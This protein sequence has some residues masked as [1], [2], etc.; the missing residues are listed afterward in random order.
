MALVILATLVLPGTSEAGTPG[1]VSRVY[2]NQRGDTMPYQ[3]FVPANYDATRAYPLV[4]WL[5]GGGG[6]G[7]DNQKQMTD[8]N[9]VGATIWTSPRNQARYPAFVLAPQC[10]DGEMWTTIRPTVEP[11]ARLED[12][13]ALVKQLQRTYKIDSR[14]LYVAGQS[15]GGYGT[16]A[17]IAA[18]PGMFAAAVPICGGGDEAK[19]KRLTT[20]AV[21]AFHGELDRA[22]R[23]ERSREMVAAVQR[24]GGRARLTEYKGVG[25]VVWDVAFA[26]PRLLP[27]VFAQQRRR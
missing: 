17:L 9:S 8:G 1:F 22:V 3:L 13:V 24:A 2:R 18:H 10:P 14:R 16:W 6:R 11:T 4:L 15:M 20:V 5:H 19:A 21:W 12:V 26:E 23:V 25:H 7:R 27:W